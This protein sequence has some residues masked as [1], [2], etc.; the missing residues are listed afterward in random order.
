MSYT[1]YPAIENPNGVSARIA[2]CADFHEA[3]QAKLD[4]CHAAFVTTPQTQNWETLIKIS[5]HLHRWHFF[6]VTSLI[7]LGMAYYLYFAQRR[8]LKKAGFLQG[9]KIK[10]FRR[11]HDDDPNHRTHPDPVED[12][13]GLATSAPKT[14]VYSDLPNCWPSDQSLTNY[15]PRHDSRIEVPKGAYLLMFPVHHK[16]IMDRG[17]FVDDQVKMYGQTLLHEGPFNYEG[18][19]FVRGMHRV[20]IY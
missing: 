11:I 9:K 16:Q 8:A 15:R 18:R 5:A 14:K 2:I 13:A 7:A 17:V 10:G 19:Q 1:L 6:A 3:H 4:G 12:C 20:D